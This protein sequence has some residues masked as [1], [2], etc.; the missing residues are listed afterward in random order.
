MEFTVPMIIATG[1][2]LG[3]GALLVIF[4]WGITAALS[5]HGR[6]KKKSEEE[7]ATGEI[8]ELIASIEQIVF[9]TKVQS[10]TSRE[11]KGQLSLAIQKLK[12]RS[13]LLLR[14]LDVYFVKYLEVQ[15]REF[16]RYL[17]SP[18]T[19][20]EVPE[21]KTQRPAP[22]TPLKIAPTP[23]VVYAATPENSG[24]IPTISNKENAVPTPRMDY[25]KAI[26]FQ[27]DKTQLID[28]AMIFG[29]TAKPLDD[30]KKTKV[31]VDKI[32]F[33][34]QEFGDANPETVVYSQGSDLE[35]CA[36]EIPAA[37]S[38]VFTKPS[39]DS[40]EPPVDEWVSEQDG[41]DGVI[42]DI[43]EEP[44]YREEL[45]SKN[46]VHQTAVGR[47]SQQ[48]SRSTAIASAPSH[49]HAQHKQPV[50]AAAQDDAMVTGD[51][52]SNKLDSLFG[53]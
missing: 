5:R 49:V 25:E 50:S 15:I 29:G 17:D 53:G 24:T 14:D 18:G 28:K 37:A 1:C 10:L 6:K 51:D 7:A 34:P 26:P 16:E 12:K 21:L 47:Q 23:E 36:G 9:S 42:L 40:L 22:V 46:G 3:T 13:S 38:H 39:L 43:P 48:P 52:I 20:A 32:E 4:L 19:P 45:L 31:P 41:A 27:Y 33:P 44:A 35:E 2:G 8:S 30:V 11:F